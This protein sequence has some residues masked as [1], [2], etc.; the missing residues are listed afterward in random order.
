MIAFIF[1]NL[2]KIKNVVPHNNFK[3]SDYYYQYAL[4]NKS[5]HSQIPT[6]IECKIK[7]SQYNVL[8]VIMATDCSMNCILPSIVS[9]N[10]ILQFVL[11]AFKET[12]LLIN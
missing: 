10:L 11:G 8:L 5:C 6:T 4:F 7:L 2:F 1:V 3:L 9:V 12:S